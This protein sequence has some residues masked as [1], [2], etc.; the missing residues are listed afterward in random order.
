[1]P[2]YQ[3][4]RQTLEMSVIDS[5]QADELH[6][7]GRQVLHAQTREL[8]AVIHDLHCRDPHKDQM[9][10]RV[11]LLMLQAVGVSIQSVLTLTE[12]RG[13]ALGT[14]SALHGQPWR[15]P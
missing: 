1:L 12:S 13:M 10:I 5:T 3:P 7:R 2:N 11:P 15:P 8:D 9:A 4:L 14:V 6:Q